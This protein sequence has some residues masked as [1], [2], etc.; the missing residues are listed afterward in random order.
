[1]ALH[2][3]FEHLTSAG[4]RLTA[5]GHLWGLGG[6][7]LLHALG[8]AEH[9]GDWDLQTDASAEACEALF[10]GLPYQRYDANGCHADHK[11]TLL[12]S[13][14]EIIIRFAFATPGGVVRIPARVSGSWRGVP[15]A[16]A[17]GWAVAYWLL[18]ELDGAPERSAKAGK[19]L[20]H[21]ATWGADRARLAELL[22]QPLPGALAER[23]RALP[24]RS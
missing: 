20:A 21:L 8:L 24:T 4:A 6:S 16:A 13:D 10:T 11:L 1:M 17:E 22:A 12:D 3:P 9:V 18:G 23:L 2:P 19:L 15:L 7:G 5:A 14:A